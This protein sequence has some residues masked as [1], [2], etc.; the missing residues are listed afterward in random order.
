MTNILYVKGTANQ[1]TN[2]LSPVAALSTAPTLALDP[3]AVVRL[4]SVDEKLWRLSKSSTSVQTTH[5]HFSDIFVISDIYARTASFHSDIFA[6]T[7][8]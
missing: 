1:P 8:L 2:A 6:L 7:A 3:T 4:Q 5:V